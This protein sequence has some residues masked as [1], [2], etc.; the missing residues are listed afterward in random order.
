MN[1]ESSKRIEGAEGVVKWFDPHKGFGFI[2]GPDGQDVFVHFTRIMGD[3]YRVLKDGSTVEYDAEFGAK[4]WRAMR[5][6]RMEEPAEVTI[7][8]KPGYSRSP[9]R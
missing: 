4:G 7:R 9:R 3:G 8:P 6:V 1:N 5:V 2:N